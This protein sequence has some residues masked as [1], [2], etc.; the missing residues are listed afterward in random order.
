LVDGA[1][2]QRLQHSG[3]HGM[4]ILQSRSGRHRH[5]AGCT[6]SASDPYG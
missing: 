2:V 4:P 5:S 6:H 3:A 1:G